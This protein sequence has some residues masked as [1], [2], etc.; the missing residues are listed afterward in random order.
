MYFTKRVVRKGV[1]MEGERST[2]KKWHF[3]PGGF[4]VPV[5]IRA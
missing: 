3:G 1:G 5:G 4:E 2:E